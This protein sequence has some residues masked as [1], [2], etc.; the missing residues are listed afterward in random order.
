M[1]HPFSDADWSPDQALIWMATRR[2]DLVNEA[3][4]D[5]FV[6]AEKRLRWVS[7]LLRDDAGEVSREEIEQQLLQAIKR[8]DV[9]TTVD[10]EPVDP[11]V[12]SPA[13]YVMG[14]D[15]VL[16]RWT[17]QV[18]FLTNILEGDARHERRHQR[19]LRPR[20]EITDLVRLYPNSAAAAPKTVATEGE[21]AGPVRSFS[22]KR[23]K[24]KIG[25]IKAVADQRKAMRAVWSA[26]TG[27]LKE[28]AIAAAREGRGISGNIAAEVGTKKKAAGGK[29]GPKPKYEWDQIRREALRLLD[30][31]GG[32]SID[33]P[34]LDSQEALVRRLL[35]FSEDRWSRAP[36]ESTMRERVSVW[37]AEYNSGSRK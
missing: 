7:F 19:E 3:S 31:Y 21:A 4:D 29:R 12:Y 33:E 14:P 36:S 20:L 30:H 10:G 15:G 23:K 25:D 35:S 26:A 27:A 17:D 9:S 1:K 16:F 22:L 2:A 37:I 18:P 6:P 8:G 24:R 28:E 11:R 34:E 5:P 13:R 32:V